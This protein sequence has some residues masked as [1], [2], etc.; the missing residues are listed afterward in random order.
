MNKPHPKYNVGDI[1]RINYVA[2]RTKSGDSVTD[3]NLRR[4]VNGLFS[5]VR[6]SL[7]P[8]GSFNY[9]LDTNP[10]A[11]DR[12]GRVTGGDWFYEEELELMFSV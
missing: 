8:N 11:R 10:L 6:V 1:V 9:K 3:R 4:Y 5:I 2:D 12:F 7:Q